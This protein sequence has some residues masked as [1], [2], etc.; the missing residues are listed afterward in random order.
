M[1]DKKVEVRAGQ[2]IEDAPLLRPFSFNAD[3]R[4]PTLLYRDEPSYPTAASVAEWLN[5]K[6]ILTDKGVTEH[7]ME[8][9]LE[10][11]ELQGRLQQMRGGG[12]R[13]DLATIRTKASNGFV[14]SPCGICPVF[15]RCGD[16]GEITARTCKYFADWL[17]TESEDV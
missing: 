17:G 8:E 1:E 11:M 6:E 7:D 9:I 12:Y 15:D 5:S 10:M 3:P 2:D 4:A 13:T 14:D 16:T